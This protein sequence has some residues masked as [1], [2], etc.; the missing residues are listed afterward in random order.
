MIDSMVSDLKRTSQRA[1]MHLIDTDNS[2]VMGTGEGW[3]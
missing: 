1:N 2:V 3:V